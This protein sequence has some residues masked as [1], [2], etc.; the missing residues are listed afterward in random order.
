MSLAVAATMARMLAQPLAQR[1]EFLLAPVALRATRGLRA[2]RPLA[3]EV[4]ELAPDAGVL[5]KVTEMAGHGLLVT[6]E[7]LLLAADLPREVDDAAVRL[8]L[9]ERRL[10][11]LAGSLPPELGHEVHGHVVA[12]AETRVERVGAAGGE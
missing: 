12:G 8:E 1:G 11:N 7:R 4:G 10:E 2:P 9:G 3:F 5:A 6:G